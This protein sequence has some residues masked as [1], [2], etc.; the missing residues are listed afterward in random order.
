M[1][2]YI[3]I[4]LPLTNGEGMLMIIAHDMYIYLRVDEKYIRISKPMANQDDC[5]NK[6]AI[7]HV[8]NCQA[9]RPCLLLLYLW[10][11]TQMTPSTVSASGCTARVH[12]Q[13]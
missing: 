10:S 13:R 11:I 5:S 8:N 1:N 9:T 3:F 4:I 12:N 7:M 2:C 6:S